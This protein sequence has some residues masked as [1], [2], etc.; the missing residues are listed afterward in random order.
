MWNLQVEGEK[1]EGKGAR[2]VIPFY[3]CKETSV[4]F[5][6]LYRLGLLQHLLEQWLCLQVFM[7]AGAEGNY[8]HKHLVAHLRTIVLE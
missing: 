4:P 7:L 5:F 6:L 8:V 2:C 3:P 1:T